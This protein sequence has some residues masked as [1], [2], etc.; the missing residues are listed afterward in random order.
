MG[1]WKCC[2]PAEYLNLEY[3]TYLVSQYFT[4]RPLPMTPSPIV[5]NATKQAKVAA[6]DFDYRINWF[7]T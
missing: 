5:L 2:T 7:I 1:A 4:S 3:D 6:N